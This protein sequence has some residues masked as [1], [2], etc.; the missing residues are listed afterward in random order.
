M[1]G[2][3]VAADYNSD[4]DMDPSSATFIPTQGDTTTGNSTPSRVQARVT[5]RNASHIELSSVKQKRGRSYYNH[6]G[7]EPVGGVKR[8]LPSWMRPRAPALSISPKHQ[9]TPKSI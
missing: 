4:I 8:D 2:L 9:K 7:R 1:Q 3:R 5:F 6:A